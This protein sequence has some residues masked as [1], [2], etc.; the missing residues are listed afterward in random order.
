[1]YRAN[2]YIYIIY[3]VYLF[4]YIQWE[5]LEHIVFLSFVMLKFHHMLSEH[6]L[7]MGSC[8]RKTWVM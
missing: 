8:K 1:M 3:Y 2:L 7:D 5:W 4:V 6:D